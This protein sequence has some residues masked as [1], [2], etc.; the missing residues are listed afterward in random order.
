MSRFPAV[1]IIKYSA[2]ETAKNGYTKR[3]DNSRCTADVVLD[4]IL[5]DSVSEDEL[6]KMSERIKAW[7]EYINDTS[8]QTGEYFD[9]VRSEI[10]KP[11]VEES[12]IGLIASSFASYDRYAKYVEAN[13]REKMSEYLGEEDDRITFNIKDYKLVKTGISNLGKNTNKWYLYRMHDDKMNVIVLFSNES[14]EIEFK[15]YNKARATISK[16]SSYNGVKQTTISK[17]S[18]IDE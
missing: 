8:K 18:F 6:L 4:M 11:M 1:K 14:L 3:T 17:I 7:H 15:K 5:D 12:K 13:E 16:L 2:Y 10:V 9:N